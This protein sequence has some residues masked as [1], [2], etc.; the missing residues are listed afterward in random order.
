[1]SIILGIHPYV[2]LS[3][4][5]PRISRMFTL[6]LVKRFSFELINILYLED[7]GES[8]YTWLCCQH[9]RKY[10]QQYL[11]NFSFRNFNCSIVYEDR[12]D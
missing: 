7:N 6:K 8:S 1:M 9:L 11:I 5:L 3:K 2:R 12:E 10:F 4:D